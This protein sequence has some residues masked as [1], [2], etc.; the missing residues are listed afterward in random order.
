MGLLVNSWP[1]LL[2]GGARRFASSRRS[3]SPLVAA[4]LGPAGGREPLL[5]GRSLGWGKSQEK[6][7][8]SEP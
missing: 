1:L 3:I 6:S 8:I 2:C 7:L 5:L 4:H